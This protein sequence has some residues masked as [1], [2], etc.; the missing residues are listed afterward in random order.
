M[1]NRVSVIGFGIRLGYG[2]TIGTFAA[3]ASACFVGYSILN[4]SD[5]LKKSDKKEVVEDGTADTNTK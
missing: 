4:F 5:K 2:I 1:G 3:L